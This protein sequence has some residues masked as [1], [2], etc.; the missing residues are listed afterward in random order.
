MNVR[1]HLPI[2]AW[3][4]AYDRSFAEAHPGGVLP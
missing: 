2:L 4:P 3:L 1:R